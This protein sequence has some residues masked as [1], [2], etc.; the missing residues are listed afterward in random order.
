MLAD[1]VEKMVC[2]DYLEEVE[3]KEKKDKMVVLDKMVNL[4][5]KEVKERLD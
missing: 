5:R 4:E 2:L 1:Q 3:Q